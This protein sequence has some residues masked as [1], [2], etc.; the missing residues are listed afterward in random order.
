EDG[1]EDAGKDWQAADD[2]AQRCPVTAIQVSTASRAE[3]DERARQ[4]AG[5]AVAAPA[6]STPSAPAQATA[7]D[8]QAVAQ[9]L[10]GWAAAWTAKDL[11]RYF[12]FYAKDFAPAKSTTAKW[13]NERRRLLSKPGPIDVQVS[14]V[15]SVPFQDTVVTSFTQTYT[16]NNFKDKTL[17]VLTWKRID[18]QWVIVKESN[19]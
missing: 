18:G 7:T 16:S 15:K 8:A 5:V 13:T 14:G 10:N 9:R 2:A 4:L 3:L 12:S 19:R 17:K 6:L 11:D 1:L